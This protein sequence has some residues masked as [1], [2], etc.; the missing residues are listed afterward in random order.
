MNGVKCFV[1]NEAKSAIKGPLRTQ[2][3]LEE[4]KGYDNE[5]FRRREDASKHRIGF[6]VSFIPSLIG[7]SGRSVVS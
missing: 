1:D 4:R 6:A 7:H 2:A 3:R 5:V